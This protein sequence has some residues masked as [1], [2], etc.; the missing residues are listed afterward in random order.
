MAKAELQTVL[1]RTV[2][3][4]ARAGPGTAALWRRVGEWI[5]LAEAAVTLGLGVHAISAPGVTRLEVT[6]NVQTPAL[7]PAVGEIPLGLPPGVTLEPGFRFPPPAQLQP[8]ESPAERS[9]P[10][11]PNGGTE[12]H[13][14]TD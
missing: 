7:P 11:E 4:A 1:G 10:G 13:P 14:R 2:A 6:C 3:T 8:G 12:Q 9:H 5:V